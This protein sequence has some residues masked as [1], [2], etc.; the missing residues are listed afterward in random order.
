MD[1]LSGT[2]SKIEKSSSRNIMMVINDQK[3]TLL[4]RRRIEVTEGDEVTLAGKQVED[5]F[6]ADACFNTTTGWST[7]YPCVDLFFYLLFLL[8]GISIVLALIKPTSLI[9]L[10]IL[11]LGII[12]W[13]FLRMKRLH[14]AQN[15]TKPIAVQ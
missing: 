3:V 15:L 12:S 5:A 9:P 13:Y 14:L 2:V 10:P 1:L 7:R 8:L 11:M 4:Y 6:K